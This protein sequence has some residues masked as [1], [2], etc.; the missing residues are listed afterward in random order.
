MVIRK[1]KDQEYWDAINTVKNLNVSIAQLKEQLAGAEGIKHKCM[2]KI[3]P[4]EN[5]SIDLGSR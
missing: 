5:W 3:F 4:R 2:Q 1:P